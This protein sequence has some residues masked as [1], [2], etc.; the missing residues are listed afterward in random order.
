MMK[1]KKGR[2]KMVKKKRSRV[3]IE[4]A[5]PEEEYAEQL[6]VKGEHHDCRGA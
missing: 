6:E 5:V 3:E 1:K 4:I 2:W